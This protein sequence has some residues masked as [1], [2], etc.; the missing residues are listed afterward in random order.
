M[1]QTNKELPNNQT[2]YYFIYDW[3]ELKAHENIGVPHGT[4]YILLA[5]I[6][7]ILWVLHT[8]KTEYFQQLW[9]M[10]SISIVSYMLE[11]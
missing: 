11:Q 8:Q 2:W 4:R 9:R 7:E 1:L 5:A 3:T 6:V 10:A